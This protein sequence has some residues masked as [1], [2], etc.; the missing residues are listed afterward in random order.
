MNRWANCSDGVE[1]LVYCPPVHPFTRKS[2]VNVITDSA[3]ATLYRALVPQRLCVG[4]S[5]SD[6]LVFESSAAL[7]LF[8]QMREAAPT[9][10]FVYRVS[11]DVRV[12][13]VAQSVLDC[14]D[15]I[16][17]EFDLISVPSR[18]L[19]ST[20]FGSQTAARFHPHGVDLDRLLAASEGAQPKLK[21]PACVSL[22][23]TLFDQELLAI[24]A[25]ARPDISFYIIGAVPQERRFDKGNIIWTGEQPFTQALKM[26]RVA[27]LTAAFYRAEPGTEYL[28][29]TSNKMAQYA[30]YQ[31]PILGP[32][33]LASAQRL[34]NFVPVD[35]PTEDGAKAAIERA[36]AMSPPE[37]P[38][39]LVLP[40]AS[41]RDKIVAELWARLEQPNLTGPA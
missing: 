35:P 21:R 12:I 34:V 30:Y 27:D 33:H 8:D 28:A 2:G 38:A 40:W 22:G 19:L 39:D 41:V 24:C 14:E 6:I 7:L 25:N 15:R 9:A 29:E 11:D 16:V 31:K 17:G 20:R 1:T 10:H 36:L 37:A 5:D 3:F 4:V 23:T 26:A 13:G 32:R 18:K